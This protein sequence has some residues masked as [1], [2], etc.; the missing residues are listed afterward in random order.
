MF[1]SGRIFRSRKFGQKFD[2]KEP[3]HLFSLSVFHLNSF[4]LS[5]GDIEF[6]SA[7]IYN[8]FSP[9]GG[10]LREPT[11]EIYNGPCARNG[12]FRED[13]RATGRGYTS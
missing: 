13:L 5:K 12:I 7:T 2:E 3:S 1:V 10:A 9:N 6:Q 11:G 4:L 8:F